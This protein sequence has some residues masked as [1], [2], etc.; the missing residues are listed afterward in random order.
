MKNSKNFKKLKVTFG[1]G[2][3]LS[4]FNNKIL[5]ICI[6][7]NK[8]LEAYRNKLK[9]YAF[10]NQEREIGARCLAFP[11]YGSNDEMI[12]GISVTGPYSR[13]TDDLLMDK[14]DDYREIMLQLSR[15]VGYQ[16]FNK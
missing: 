7:D 3:F 2:L 4:F 12:G 13:L 6:N 5:V 9:G 8:Y 1:Q 10:D 11:I 14:I 16:N 15:E